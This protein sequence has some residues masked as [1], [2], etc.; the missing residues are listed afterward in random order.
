MRNNSKYKHFCRIHTDTCC[1]D[2][3]YKRDKVQKIA[4]IYFKKPDEKSGFLCNIP[5]YDV[6]TSVGFSKHEEEML[7][8]FVHNNAVTFLTGGKW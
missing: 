7:L 8:E 6:V 4:T 1:I 5:S 2:V 3:A